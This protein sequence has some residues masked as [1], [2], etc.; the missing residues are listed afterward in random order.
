LAGQPWYTDL[1]VPIVHITR[2][3]YKK[4]QGLGTEYCCLNCFVVSI[5]ITAGL[6]AVPAAEKRICG[7]LG[8]RLG[9]YDDGPLKTQFRTLCVCR[10]GGCRQYKPRESGKSLQNAYARSRHTHCLGNNDLSSPDPP[11]I[12]PRVPSMLLENGGEDSR[13]HLLHLSHLSHISR[14]TSLAQCSLA[15]PS[16]LLLPY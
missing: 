15:D 1:V 6:H 12:F 11:I 3:K 10:L 8:S 14:P 9:C 16:P 2:L 5:E 7:D 13:P 4:C